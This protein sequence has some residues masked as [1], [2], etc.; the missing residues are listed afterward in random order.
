MN[1][2]CLEEEKIYFCF[3]YGLLDSTYCTSSKSLLVDIHARMCF[4]TEFTVCVS[5]ELSRSHCVWTVHG[6]E[7]TWES[8]PRGVKVLYLFTVKD[9]KM[10][11]YRSVFT[12]ALLTTNKLVPSLWSSPVFSILFQTYCIKAHTGDKSL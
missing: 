11:I 4:R 1:I 5:Y 9:P 7:Y 6:H 10:H 8:G 2:R 12:A 3:V